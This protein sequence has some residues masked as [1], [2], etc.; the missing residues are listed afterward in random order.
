MHDVAE[1]GLGAVFSAFLPL[2]IH[3][4]G[5][6][7]DTTWLVASAGFLAASSLS[8]GASFW[9]RGNWLDGARSEP[10]QTVI[11]MPLQLSA[12]GLVLANF[13]APGPSSGARYVAAI[14]L[15]LAIGGVLFVNATFNTADAPPDGRR[16]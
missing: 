5:A 3:A 11:T 15:S 16:E 8:A 10:I 1:I 12:L 4:F 2:V 7:T 6:S 14:L 13:A 9:R